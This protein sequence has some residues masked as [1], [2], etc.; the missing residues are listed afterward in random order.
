MVK[1]VFPLPWTGQNRPLPHFLPINVQTKDDLLD[2][3]PWSTWRSCKSYSC[4]E[5][6]HTH[7]L[8]VSLDAVVGLE[9]LSTK[10]A[11]KHMATVLPNCVLFRRYPLSRLC[12]VPRT[13]PIQ[14]QHDFPQKST[15][16]TCRYRSQQMSAPLYVL[17]E[18]DPCLEGDVL[19]GKAA[20]PACHQLNLGRY[21]S[22]NISRD[23]QLHGPPCA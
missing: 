23:S 2:G 19:D 11:D 1:D 6:R 7:K 17:L 20:S 5:A 10:L 14:Q 21:L 16:H 4:G 18:T 8:L 12:F 13:D 3:G 15:C 22:C 9:I